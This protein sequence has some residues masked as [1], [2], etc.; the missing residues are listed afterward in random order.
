MR[1]SRVKQVSTVLCGLPVVLFSA[2]SEAA[3]DTSIDLEATIGFDDNVTR[4]EENKDI[5]YAGF[6]EVIG[7]GNHLLYVDKIGLLRAKGLLSLTNV[8]RFNGLSHVTAGGA[9]NYTFGFWEDFRAPWFS[10][11][12]GYEL[13]EFNSGLRDSDIFRANFSMGMNLDDATS[14]LTGFNYNKRESDG[15]AFDT[16]DSSFFINFDWTVAKR[17]TIYL[18]Y[19]IQQGDTFSLAQEINEVEVITASKAIEQ[20]DVFKDKLAY[21]L[22]ATVQFITLGYNMAKNLNTSF[23]FSARYLEADADDVNL[24]YEGLTLRATYFHRFSL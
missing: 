22:D 13:K 2:Q 23:D 16:T 9:L 20:D 19:K 3:S 11:E 15:T 10:A 4:A 24:Q 18:T 14:I 8:S 7:T 1:Y 5:E 17:K 21:R 12:V 6:I